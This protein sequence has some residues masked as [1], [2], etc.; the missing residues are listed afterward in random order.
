MSVSICIS[1]S[2]CVSDGVGVRSTGAAIS[3]LRVGG[4]AM[5]GLGHVVM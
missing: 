2:V 1:M 3:S 5:V 4:R